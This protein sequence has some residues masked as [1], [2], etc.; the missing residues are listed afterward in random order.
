MR[1]LLTLWKWSLVLFFGVELLFHSLH[2]NDVSSLPSGTVT[3]AV[4]VA[5]DQYRRPP[6]G[7]SSSSV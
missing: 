4:T 6:L 1:G 2:D 5:G 3:V 7:L